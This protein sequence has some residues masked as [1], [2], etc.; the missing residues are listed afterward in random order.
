MSTL[1]IGVL[2]SVMATA[3][4]ALVTFLYRS[5]KNTAHS[6][7]EAKRLYSRLEPSGVR[8]VY[9]QRSDYV[10]HSLGGATIESYVETANSSLLYVGYWLAHGTEIANVVEAFR[11]ITERGVAVEIVLLSESLPS[12]LRAELAAMLGLSETELAQRV[13]AAWQKF[14]TLQASLSVP[15]KA[16]F[17]LKSHQH[18]L[19]ASIFIFDKED[20]TREKLHVDFK[21]FGLGRGDSFSMEMSPGAAPNSLYSRYKRAYCSLA[22]AANQVDP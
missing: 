16:R 18:P 13:I 12:P 10:N 7:G 1:T 4:V 15:G 14:K 2:G 11:K 3:I 22:V 19:G 8:Q 17:V 6:K 5:G 21:I 20:A 9:L